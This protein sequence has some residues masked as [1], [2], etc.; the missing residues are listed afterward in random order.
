MGYSGLSGYSGYSG[1]SGY[2]GNIGYSGLSGYSGYSGMSGYS[3]RSGY[4]GLA[5]T[6]TLGSWE[7]KANDTTYTASTDGFV[8][9]YGIG[10]HAGGQIYGYTPSTTLRQQQGGGYTDFGLSFVMPVRAGDTWK[11]TQSSAVS[12][13]TVYWISF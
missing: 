11:V 8:V 3:G 7:T 5:G 1:L 4:S 12:S 2:S 9:A 6:A 10:S 13:V